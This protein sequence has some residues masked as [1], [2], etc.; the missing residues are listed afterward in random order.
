[1][2]GKSNYKIKD[3]K[4][5]ISSC[6]PIADILDPKD[7]NTFYKIICDMYTKYGH[8]I[9]DNI[10]KI[11]SPSVN[12][13][14]LRMRTLTGAYS[15]D[16]MPVSNNVYV[17]IPPVFYVFGLMLPFITR[18]AQVDMYGMFE[19]L[20]QLSE[21]KQLNDNEMKLIKMSMMNDVKIMDLDDM[22]LTYEEQINVLVYLNIF[23]HVIVNSLFKMDKESIPKMIEQNLLNQFNSIMDTKYKLSCVYDKLN[24]ND[25]YNVKVI[26]KTLLS[27][28][29]RPV[30][31]RL[32]NYPLQ[33]KGTP[34]LQS[35]A[36]TSCTND[37]LEE[38][39]DSIT[40]PHDRIDHSDYED[41]TSKDPTGDRSFFDVKKFLDTYY[42]IVTVDNKIYWAQFDRAYGIFPL[43]IGRRDMRKKKDY[44][45][46][47]VAQAECC[48]TR[49][50]TR[51]INSKYLFCPDFAAS[52]PSVP[53]T[54]TGIS[55]GLE[56]NGVTYL[57]MALM[58]T[59]LSNAD[60]T[61]SIEDVEFL[62]INP[63]NEV[64]DEMNIPDS[65][66][67]RCESLY[68]L[69]KRFDEH[70][71][72][73]QTKPKNNYKHCA[74]TSSPDQTSIDQVLSQVDNTCCDQQTFK[75]FKEAL[76]NFN[77]G[78]LFLSNKSCSSPIFVDMGVVSGGTVTSTGMLGGKPVKLVSID[79][80]KCLIQSS[81]TTIL[82]VTDIDC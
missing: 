12:K 37:E 19:Q 5:L 36:S 6:V 13:M 62:F 4:P 42:K 58:G 71:F 59:F 64:P 32:R 23:Y 10:K 2:V 68:L 81:V 3:M 74:T 40:V 34:V 51:Q 46:L 65:K 39:V 28:G 38:F 9:K 76:T 14:I 77:V 52:A 49:F 22:P 17:E 26:R 80:I 82:Y 60:F 1:M 27:F 43:F 63:F 66:L 61:G 75:D 24:D 73:G 57:P 25:P 67:K 16:A 30:K 11:N 8:V 7:T 31:M 54:P 55:N 15:I 70:F 41:T 72:C 44:E 29:I 21:T 47:L 53:S 69:L 18:I 79:Q 56:V 50:N 45:Q 20:T 33:S 78:L 48:E 35:L